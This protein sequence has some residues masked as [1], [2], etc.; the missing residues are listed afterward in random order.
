MGKLFGTD[1]IRGMAN[2]YPITPEMAL[3]IGRAT[4]HLFKREG[5]KT[6]ILIGKDTRISGDMLEHALVAGICSMG[7]DALLA[8]V[9]PTPGVAFLTRSMALDAGVM[10][11]A[12]HNPFYDNGI[13]IFRGDGFKLSDETELAV[14]DLVLGKAFAESSNTLQIVGRAY[15]V[16]DPCGHYVSFLKDEVAKDRI[17]EGLHVILDCANGATLQ[18]APSTFSELGAR[19]KTLFAEGNGSNIN[20]NCGSE[21]LEGLAK[22]VVTSKADVG[23]AFDG[24]GDRVIAV[25]EKGGRLAGD[26]MLAIFA[27]VMKDEGR[28]AN[29]VVVSTVMSNLG[30]RLALKGLGVE[31]VTT[32]VGDRH[33]LQEMLARGA[34]IGGENSGHMIFLDHHTTGDGIMTALNL[35]GAMTRTG[36]PLSEL[37]KIMKVFPQCLINV[38]V[39]RK[40]P[41]ERVP[42]IVAAV[43][44]AE[45]A[46]GDEGRVLVRYSGTQAMCRVMVEGPSHE[47]TEKHCREIAAVVRERL[48]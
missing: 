33:V 13:K 1:G 18:A 39:K 31:Q 22:E 3:K 41:I 23:F 25:D 38:E 35:V 42:E 17:L 20:L 27:K 34:C 40:P 6:Q 15:P 8:G 9:L 21:H 48:N 4:A 37:S 46:L 11:S 10:I 29:N 5:H 19:V 45:K 43:E 14:E 32:R 7:A 2:Q 44:R 30:L 28:L 36:E 16:T 47:E 12:S 26:Q 24:D